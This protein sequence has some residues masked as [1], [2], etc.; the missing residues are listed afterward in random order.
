MSSFKLRQLGKTAMKL[1]S[2]GYGTVG[3]SNAFVNDTVNSDSLQTLDASWAQGVRF[4]DT[5]PYYG[6]G[7][8]EHRLGSFLR[9]KEEGTYM[10]STKVGRV[11]RPH[12]GD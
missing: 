5:A 10:L 7:L 1:P 3:L 4:Y 2:L 8:A 11:L 12:I 9:E 6:T